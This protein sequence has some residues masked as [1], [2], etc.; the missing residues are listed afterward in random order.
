MNRQK[1]TVVRHCVERGARAA[2]VTLPW[3]DV[4]RPNAAF[5]RQAFGCDPADPALKGDQVHEDEGEVPAHQGNKEDALKERRVYAAAD[6]AERSD[7]EDHGLLRVVGSHAK[8]K[9]DC[10]IVPTT[11]YTWLSTDQKGNCC[12]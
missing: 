4:L 6:A 2:A 9:D 7:D 10:V 3:G 5:A 8:E 11:L 1:L 12:F